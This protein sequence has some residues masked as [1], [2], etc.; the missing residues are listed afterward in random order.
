MRRRMAALL[1][2]LA[3][4]GCGRSVT[5]TG[6]MQDEDAVEAVWHYG[7][8]ERAT[9]E[10]GAFRLEGLRGDPLDLRFTSEDG[11]H[12]RMEI[13][14]IGGGARVDLLGVW[15]EDGV[16]H[17]SGVEMEGADRVTI[18]GIRFA[19]PGS[20]PAELDER[21]LVLAI[22]R[23]GDALLVR[24]L[25]DGLPDLRVVVTPATEV[26]SPDGD[27][28]SVGAAGV[29]DT[30]RVAGRTESGYLVATRLELPRRAAT[31]EGGGDDDDD[32][33]DVRRGGGIDADRER[34]D[35]PGRGK[36][37]GRGRGRD[38]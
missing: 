8:E 1:A 12:G 13:T 29:D 2:A 38:G 24:P 15:L 19:A 11:R 16:A 3:A 17:A 37:R 31:R 36:G 27:P 21:G 25:N 14:G 20:L 35:K 30:V 18:N 33:D 32:D 28:V 5:V 4:S 23:S 6:T 34:D 7:G 9:V 26:V 10:A 22:G